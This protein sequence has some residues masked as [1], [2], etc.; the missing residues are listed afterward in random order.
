MK[1]NNSDW[2]N[3]AWDLVEKKLSRVAISAREILPY[4]TE[5]GKYVNCDADWWTNGFWPGMMWLMYDATKKNIY[6]ETAETAEKLLD[7]AL[8][9]YDLLHHDV[10]F[11]WHLSS[12]ANYRLTGNKKSYTRNMFAANVLAGRFNLKSGY[13]RAWNGEE[14]KG[15]AIIDCMMNIPLL[16][17]ASEVEKDER[18]KYIA[19]SHADKT[20][21]HH[22]RP[23]GSVTHL[24]EFDPLTGE[25]IKSHDGQGY[26]EGSSWSRG[27]GW[28][29][30]G[31]TLSYIHTKEQRYLDAA[32][33]VA[34]Y[35]ISAVCNDWIA[36]CDFRAPDEPIIYDSSAGLIAACGLLELSKCVNELESKTYYTSACNIVK[37]TIDNF[38]D[39]SDDTDAIVTHG[40]VAYHF[41]QKHINMIYSD[42]YFV[43]ALNKLKG[44]NT[45]LW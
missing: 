4:T 40:T 6:K 9:E 13:I 35:F 28:G 3:Q 27:Q 8:S 23:D 38:T 14:N 10:G 16:Y 15:F 19:M 22:L 44:Y 42:Y 20:L 34:H 31:F 2:I 25:I 21:E 39:F 24:V 18:F 36:K 37:A 45:F 11:M 1:D 32:K 43:E 29:L 12:G 41:G 17:W 5:N 7:K 30:Y 26:K 33:R